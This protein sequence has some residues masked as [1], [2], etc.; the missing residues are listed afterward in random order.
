MGKITRYMV[1]LVLSFCVWIGSATAFA[2]VITVTGEGSYTMGEGIGESVDIARDRAKANALL[3]ASEQAGVFLKSMSVVK[4][5]L[6]EKDDIRALASTLLKVQGSPRFQTENVSGNAVRFSCEV[7]ASVDTDSINEKLLVD[8][9]DSLR[10][11]REMEDEVRQTNQQMELLRQQFATASSFQ[12]KEEIQKKI[13]AN[14]REFQAGQ[15]LT[16][17][18]RFYLEGL[19]GSAAEAFSSAISIAPEYAY[20]YG[21]RGVIYDDKLNRTQEALEDFNKAIELKPQHAGFYENRGRAYAKRK[22]YDKALADYD[23]AIR[24]NPG[25]ASCYFNR[26]ASYEAIGEL[27]KALADYDR[28]IRI[29]P[30]FEYAYV[31][32][33]NVYAKSREYRQAIACYK[34]AL[35]LNPRDKLACGNMAQAYGILGENAKAVESYTRAITL[36]PD[37]VNLY[38]NRGNVYMWL[39]SYQNAIADFS[40]A[41]MAY[42]R[43]ADA[44]VGRGVAYYNLHDYRKALADFETAQQLNSREPQ[45]PDYLKNA[46]AAVRSLGL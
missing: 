5:N 1:A 2:K 23:M 26:G 35:S 21:N 19:Y 17:G 40:K 12:Q 30:D 11:L 37:N 45:L 32:K 15:W 46:R 43:I 10:Q 13:Q 44:Y 39:E 8:R 41:I 18:N 29:N 16:A 27:Q 14:E 3:N 20:A 36:D 9:R 42:P 24:L 7:T 22:E 33:G 28:T 4:M 38:Y 34:K 6:L 25:G 31:N